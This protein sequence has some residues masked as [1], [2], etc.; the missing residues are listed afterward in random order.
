MLNFD[1]E[2]C[3]HELIEMRAR[4]APD[5]CALQSGER[6]LSYRV[7]NARANYLAHQLRAAG[8]CPETFLGV[9]LPRSIE[10][11]IAILGILKSGAAYV[12]LDP[13]YPVA[14]REVMVTDCKP[15]LILKSVPDGT[16]ADPGDCG[17]DLTSAAYLIYTSGSTG[18]PKGTI[19]VH[20]SLTARLASAPLPDIQGGDICAWNSSL[21]FG[22]SASRLFL[23]LAHGLP[24]AIIGED[25]VRDVMAFAEDLAEYKV[26]SAFMV[27]A[28]LRQLLALGPERTEKLSR[29]RAVTVSGGVL[30]PDLVNSYFQA[31]PDAILVNN[32]GSSEIGTSG[33]SKIYT[34]STDAR[35]ITI[36][37]PAANTRILLLDDARN[38][39]PP[40]ETGEIN[41]VAPHLTRGYLNLPE[42]TDQKFFTLAN[43]ERMY[44]TGDIGRLA[45]NGEIQFLGRRDQ[46]VKIR[47]FRVELGE[48]ESLLEAH[49]GVREVGVA[50]IP[51]GGDT[52]LIAALSLHAGH[53]ADPN[54][55]REYLSRLLPDYMIPSQFRFQDEL[56]HTAAGK[57]DRSALN[58]SEPLNGPR[59]G[60][61]VRLDSVEA[62][63][64]RI[65]RE[66]L[67]LDSVE[68]DS[69]FI[70]L[71]G[72]SLQAVQ[73]ISQVQTL[74]GKRLGLE[75]L[76]EA[77]LAELAKQIAPLTTLRAI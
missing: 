74:Y 26:T 58:S 3:I 4:D 17:V 62:A 15:L 57:I 52:R 27:P 7:L 61:S 12:Y 65:W 1:S 28:L 25:R 34:R 11:V 63:L 19:E 30:T 8:A 45:E 38:P 67:Q 48:I 70:E 64:A 71:G 33:A 46:Q 31:F 16:R 69:N 55:F 23:P 72:D 66:V 18:A 9:S 5:S 13:A 53:V 41:V 56:P 32:Y 54:G 42:L 50:A 22:I 77:T 6:S 36:G 39:V 73:V 2:L 29:L 51:A 37:T 68:P 47:G 35:R 76:F 24:V 49:P 60:S 21:S 44:R 10:A 40:G 59:E 43:G 20:R 14:R 75:S